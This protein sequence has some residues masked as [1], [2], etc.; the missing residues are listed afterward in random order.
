[1]A[2]QTEEKAVVHTINVL[3]PFVFTWPQGPT[4]REPREKLFTVGE[5]EIDEVMAAHP[6]I[7]KHFAEGRIE[8]PE[9]RAERLKAK[10]AKIAAVA[11]QDARER[12]A[13]E[14][15]LRRAIGGIVATSKASKEEI[16]RELNTPISQLR[17]AMA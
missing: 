8:R 16:E 1:M 13:S 11:E 2:K 4:E 15:A 6:W 14:A 9:Q 12:E 7:V 5:H 10:A 17:R 3:R